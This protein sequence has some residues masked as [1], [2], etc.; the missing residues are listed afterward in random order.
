MVILLV[1]LRLLEKF[2]FLFICIL[3]ILEKAV[4]LSNV[5]LMKRNIEEKINIKRVKRI[6][7][8][9]LSGKT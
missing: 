7:L 1:L 2:F 5:K 9:F 6:S 4:I 3:N 8:C